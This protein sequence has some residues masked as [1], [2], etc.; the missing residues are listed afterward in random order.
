MTL[1]LCAYVRFRN[2][3]ILPRGHLSLSLSLSLSFLGAIIDLARGETAA[4]FVP[5]LLAR[6]I[7]L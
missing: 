3:D 2:L 1:I 4:R 5:P 7:F 6:S